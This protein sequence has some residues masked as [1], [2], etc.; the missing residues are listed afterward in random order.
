MDS[1]GL[2]HCLRIQQSQCVSVAPWA[3]SAACAPDIP[4]PSFDPRIANVRGPSQSSWL[5]RVPNRFVVGEYH[6]EHFIPQRTAQEGGE[7]SRTPAERRHTPAWEVIRRAGGAC[8]DATIG[9]LPSVR[10]TLPPWTGPTTR[11]VCARPQPDRW[12]AAPSL[13]GAGGR[14]PA[15]GSA[16]TAFPHSWGFT[17]LPVREFWC[18][19]LWDGGDGN[20]RQDASGVVFKAS[21]RGDSTEASFPAAIWVRA[22]YVWSQCRRDSK[23][24]CRAWWQCRRARVSRGGGVL[25]CDSVGQQC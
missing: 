19:A 2:E 23:A 18:T 20:R 13:P 17:C 9:S 15:P 1:Q 24:P 14:L 10:Q 12:S 6:T 11:P 22:N 7:R 25:S 21:C 4:R 16:L 3:R 5:V 8:A